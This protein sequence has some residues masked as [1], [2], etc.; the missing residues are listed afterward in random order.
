LRAH[1]LAFQIL[2]RLRD[3]FLID[4]WST[5]CHFLSFWSLANRFLLEGGSIHIHS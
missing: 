4:F 5:C 3:P 1:F 2:V